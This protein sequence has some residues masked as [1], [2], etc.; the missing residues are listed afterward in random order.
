MAR[1]TGPTNYQ[2]QMLIA[3]LEPKARE[4]RFW[5]RIVE[6]LQKPSR[7][8]RT[9]N[10]YKINQYAQDGDVVMV[11]GKVLSVGEL[12]KKIQVAAINFSAEARKKITEAK[13]KVLTIRELAQLHPD[14]KN[15]RILG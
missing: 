13:G 7:Q 15:V 6:D 12:H 2:L 14:G 3:E 10:V 9:V 4:N 8:R 5:K 1:R 11:P